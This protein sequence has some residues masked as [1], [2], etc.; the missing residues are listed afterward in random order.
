M[1][2]TW[3]TNKLSFAQS[4]RQTGDNECADMKNKDLKKGKNKK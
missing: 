3:W 1:K 2:K 4:P